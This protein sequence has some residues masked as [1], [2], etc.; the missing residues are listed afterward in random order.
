MYDNSANKIWMGGG[1]GA[2]H[3]ANSTLGSPDG[4]AGGRGAGIVLIRTPEFRNNSGRLFRCF[5]ENGP[6]AGGDGAGGGGAGGTILV[7]TNTFINAAA[8]G[9]QINGGRGGNQNW[10]GANNQCMGTGGG[11]GGGVFW[12]SGATLPGPGIVTFTLSGGV[13]GVQQGICAADGSVGALPGQDGVVL[14][15]LVIPQSFTPPNGCVLPVMFSQ[16][17]AKQK[18]GQVEILWSTASEIN[19]DYFSIERSIDGEHFSEI[20]RHPG[21]VNTD[22]FS[23][24]TIMDEEPHFGVNYY[25]VRQVDYNGASTVSGAQR[26][27]FHVDHQLDLQIYPNPLEAGENLNATFVM[28]YAG[29]I[30]MRLM[31]AYGRTLM[32]QSGDV[33]KGLV[34]LDIPI[35]ESLSGI[36]FLKINTQDFSEVKRISVLK[37]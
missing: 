31:D 6:L 32:D 10:S 37:K 13:A 27:K 33:E 9:V 34:I 8:L 1:G 22:N 17:R 23:N 3:V 25:R 15:N 7:E 4:G 16:I 24:Y 11:G 12:H 5:G 30:R 29:Y 21:H 2:G 26:V 28:P 19:N 36:Y 20:A 18:G 35:A 14:N